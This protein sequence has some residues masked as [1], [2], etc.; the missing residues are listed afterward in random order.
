MTVAILDAN[1]GTIDRR[2]IMVMYSYVVCEK[3]YQESNSPIIP[4]RNGSQN[5]LSVYSNL[6]NAYKQ[7]LGYANN[8]R[9][10]EV[11]FMVRTLKEIKTEIR[12]NKDS[13][14][15]IVLVAQEVEKSFIPSEPSIR[16]FNKVDYYIQ[17]VLP[18]QILY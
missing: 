16:I 7:L 17:V 10:L 12:E 5:I 6:E 3:S 11:P 4:L 13:T 8:T 18:D 14:N 9:V 1:L 15:F 2:V